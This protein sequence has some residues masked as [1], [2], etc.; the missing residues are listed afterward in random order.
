MKPEKRLFSFRQIQRD[1]SNDPRHYPD[2]FVSDCAELS[3]GK[4]C[5]A[6]NCPR[7]KRAEKAERK[8]DE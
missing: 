1:C 7:W 6:K 8:R 2:C 4:K 5:N 3:D